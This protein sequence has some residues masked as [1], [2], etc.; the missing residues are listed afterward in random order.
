MIRTVLKD[1]SPESVR[2]AYM[3]EHLVIDS[4]IVR[5]K[6]PHIFLDD[7]GSAVTE[8]QECLE[9]EINLFVDCMPGESGRNID[10]LKEIS[11]LSNVHIVSATGMHNS[12]YYLPDSHYL[13]ADREFYHKIMIHEINNLRCGIIKIHTT[14]AKPS[15][16]EYELFAGA[17]Q[18]QKDTGVPILTHCEEGRGALEQIELLNSLGADLDRVVLS[19]T[20]KYP[21]RSYHNEI[22]ESGINVEYDQS[23]RQL[24]QESKPSLELTVDM[25]TAG[26][27]SQIMLGTDGARRT[28]WKSLGGSPGLAALG[29][30][31]R[32]LL[33]QSGLESKVLHSLFVDNPRR[34]LSFK[35]SQV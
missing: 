16:L 33:E 13:S 17:V 12:K 32:N 25:C 6:F 9:F 24:T 23:L 3:H 31:W 27:A 15:L 10:K 5:N 20:D 26:Y 28:L 14:T 35:E 2:G 18:A 11:R 29:R 1:I 22:L 7:I 8:T 21:D 34:F 30:D 19:H 4:L